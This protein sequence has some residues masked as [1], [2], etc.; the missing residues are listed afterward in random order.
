MNSGSKWELLEWH[1]NSNEE[2][3]AQH[4]RKRVEKHRPNY[5]FA[6]RKRLDLEYTAPT[7]TLEVLVLRLGFS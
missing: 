6:N 1:S 3:L 7:K 5:T 4:R 2:L